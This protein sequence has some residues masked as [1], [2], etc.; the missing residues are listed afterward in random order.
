MSYQTSLIDA[1]RRQE[2][3]LADRDPC[4]CGQPAT[5]YLVGA[6]RPWRCRA[7][8]DRDFHDLRQSHRRERQL[9]APP[10]ADPAEPPNV[11]AA[12]PGDWSY[13]G[14]MN[15]VGSDLH[16]LIRFFQN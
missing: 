12:K 6:A 2:A 8:A 14:D 16:D 9:P 3:R 5:D 15:H 1:I 7:C 4:A 10:N 13:A 11:Q